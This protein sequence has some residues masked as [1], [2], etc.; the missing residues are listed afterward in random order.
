MKES[1]DE[2][3]LKNYLTEKVLFKEYAFR[4]RARLDSYQGVDRARFQA[5]SL[6]S[7]NPSTES[8]ALI[9]QLDKLEV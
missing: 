2:N 4:V 8:D 5:V 9:E 3:L 7:I 1:S 6:S